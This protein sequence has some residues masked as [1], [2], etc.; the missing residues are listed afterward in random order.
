MPIGGGGLK[1][2]VACG[3][4]KYVHKTNDDP[5][6]LTNL[7]VFG[8]ETFLL[9]LMCVCRLVGRAVG[10]TIH[11]SVGLSICHNFKFHVHAPIGSFVL[12]PRAYYRPRQ[13]WLG[14]YM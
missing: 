10:L 7:V 4:Q 11:W 3:S 14:V 12:F 8:S 1:Q 13:N 5:L 9:A 2:F 6:I